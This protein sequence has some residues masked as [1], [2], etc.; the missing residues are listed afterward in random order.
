[1][2]NAWVK[3]KVVFVGNASVGKTCIIASQN[4]LDQ[5]YVQP[6]IAAAS[7]AT[8]VDLDG[9]E[10]KLNVWDTAG[11]DDYRCLVPM[12]AHFSHVAVIVFSVADKSS[13]D[14][15]PSWIDYLKSNAEIPHTFLVANKIDQAIVR[16]ATAKPLTALRI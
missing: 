7:I 6:T 12:Y 5:D 4:K 16:K 13:F 10:I 9:V 15:I 3:G 1:M 8:R 11:Q 2:K 14:A